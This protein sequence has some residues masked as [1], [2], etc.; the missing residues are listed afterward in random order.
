MKDGR[1]KPDP[2]PYL[3]A[4][5]RLSV[6]PER[7]VVFEDSLSGIRSAQAADML[8]I[9]IRNAGSAQLPVVPA[10]KPCPRTGV[11][12]LMDLLDDFDELDRR[13]LF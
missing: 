9:A 5:S 8:V 11:Q 6:R 1:H 7:C 12:P 4:A 2:Y 3:L 13:F 10:E